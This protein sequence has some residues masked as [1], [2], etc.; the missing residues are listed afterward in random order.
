MT[1]PYDSV[2]GVAREDILERFRTGMPIRFHTAKKGLELHAAVVEVDEATGR[3]RS[4]RRLH[5]RGEE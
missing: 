1:G 4:I 5:V 3:A 2:I